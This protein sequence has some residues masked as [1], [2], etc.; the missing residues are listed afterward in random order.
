MSILHHTRGTQG[1]RQHPPPSPAHF[2]S[3]SCSFQL[4]FCQI[5]GWCPHL[6]NGTSPRLGSPGCT[7]AHVMFGLLRPLEVH[8]VDPLFCFKLPKLIQ[9]HS[10]KV[11]SISP[12]F[13]QM[14]PNPKW[15]TSGNDKLDSH[16]W[17]LQVRRTSDT[18][19][20][21]FWKPFVS[22]FL[23]FHAVFGE[24]LAE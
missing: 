7:T 20:G 9:Q 6:W 17:K 14:N 18:T 5:V 21:T 8:Y 2:V 13:C 10:Y 11:E 4:T 1:M 16:C 15:F 19:I 24:N 23:H 3:F 12:H 22:N